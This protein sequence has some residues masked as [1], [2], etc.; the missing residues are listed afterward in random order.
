MRFTK[1]QTPLVGYFA[2]TRALTHLLHLQKLKTLLIIVLYFSRFLTDCVVC[3]WNESSNF[4]LNNHILNLI[5]W[6]AFYY[7]LVL[8]TGSYATRIS[9][10]WVT[11]SRDIKSIIIQPAESS[12]IRRSEALKS[13]V[14][15]C[16]I[17]I[18]DTGNPRFGLNIKTRFEIDSRFSSFCRLRA[19][20]FCAELVFI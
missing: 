3:N 17:P 14:L 1:H 20:L 15:R 18:W 6:I 19:F 4:Y 2:L 13:S 12:I 9:R 10:I 5:I 16:E 8:F 7:T 11:G